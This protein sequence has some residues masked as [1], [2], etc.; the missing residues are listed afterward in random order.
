M[1]FRSEI[2]GYVRSVMEKMSSRGH[3]I[4]VVG[5]AVRDLAAGKVPDD[6]DLTTSASPEETI[7]V[8]NSFGIGYADTGLKHGTVMAIP[9]GKKVE[10]TSFR[11]EGGYKD[12]RHPDGVTF[13]KDINED[14]K[15]RD[16]TINA[17]YLDPDG[18]VTDPVG[19]LKDMEDKLIRAVGDPEERFREDALRILRALRFEALTGF[20][21][22]AE[23]RKAMIKAAPGLREIS[24]ERIA[25]EFKRTL[26]AGYASKA[27][28]GAVDII[29]IFIPELKACEGFDQRSP[30]HD[31]DVLEHTL[32]V[33]D[34]I[35]P[36]EDGKRDEALA[37]AAFFHDIAKP[38]CFYL[39]AN[40]VGHMKGHPVVSRDIA[41]KRL[42]ELKFPVKVIRE[43]EDLVLMHDTFIK[44]ERVMVR[45]L[46]ASYPAAFLDK[47]EILQR[48]DILAHAAPGQLRME[49]LEHI[50]A[51]RRQLTGEGF[52]TDIKDLD[53]NGNDIIALGVK[54]GPAVGALIHCLWEDY[55]SEKVDN[56]KDD[57]IERLRT[58]VTFPT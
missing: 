35:P 10:I 16:F 18:F 1:N 42:N 43:V 46:M 34:N 15:R 44:P 17:M 6:F 22:E 51:I 32:A 41:G 4:Y 55:L 2:P 36:A 3:E 56:N 30:Y 9:E 53:I 11:T 58:Y 31:L 37:L 20:E 54:P 47:L 5:G 8:L 23:T 33:L 14:V 50:S 28:R 57:L 24:A 19:G 21:I 29:S 52:V 49:K 45:K 7:E 13:I 27:V 26:T 39:G 25:S 12:K 38:L 48:A 40:G